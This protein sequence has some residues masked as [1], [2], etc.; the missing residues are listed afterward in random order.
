[1]PSWTNLRRSFARD[2]L[3]RYKQ[4]TSG[5]QAAPPSGSYAGVA[6]SADAQ[7]QFVS[8]D[9]GSTSITDGEEIRPDY[10]DNWYLYLLSAT[11][12]Q[13]RVSLG[14]YAPNNLASAV[15]DQAGSSIV[16]YVML[17][18]ALGAVVPAA[19]VAELHAHPI[20]DD[21]TPG[22]LSLTNQALASMRLT[23]SITVTP[24]GTRRVEITGQPWLTKQSMLGRVLGPAA[25]Y[26]AAMDTTGIGDAKLQ[27]DGEKTYLILSYGPGSTDGS[28]FVECFRPR[29]TWVLVK[30]QATATATVTAG[31]VTAVTLVDGGSGYS[32]TAT[33]TI[34]GVGT[35]ATV[36]ATVSGGSVTGFS[37]LVGGSGYVQASTTVTLSAPD[38]TT[39]TSSTTGLVN[40]AD[41]CTGTLSEITLVAYYHYLCQ[42]LGADPRGASPNLL[43]EW[44]TTA[45]AAAPL[46]VYDQDAL[47]PVNDPS[48]SYGMPDSP[49]WRAFRG[50]SFAGRGG[51]WGSWP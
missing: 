1:M 36:T 39:W 25:T 35:G 9:L 13:R 26:A 2:R 8:S 45:E 47:V 24:N 16:G 4:M 51:G 42:Q 49:Q 23:Q 28:L 40:E 46:L 30:R 14:G 31:A 37:G 7:R 5:V 17:E 18:R 27:L 50:Q 20:L 29:N 21:G 6:N 43:R 10:Y 15:T 32:G 44:K 11:P 12:E 41:E 34:G 3:R 48:G 19:T 22:V 38:T 33:A